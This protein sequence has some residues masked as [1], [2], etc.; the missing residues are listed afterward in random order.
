LD[1][2]LPVHSEWADSSILSEFTKYTHL[3]WIPEQWF[4]EM[5]SQ[6][7]PPHRA[8]WAFP[9]WY[10]QTKAWIL[11]EVEERMKLEVKGELEQVD[12]SCL[13]L[14]LRI[15]TNKGHIY[16]KASAPEALPHEGVSG[17]PLPFSCSLTPFC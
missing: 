16:F 3:K 8:P 17:S 5:E 10:L 11:S 4:N 12:L 2:K 9:G 15:N 13:S 1:I 7:S 6:T 14:I